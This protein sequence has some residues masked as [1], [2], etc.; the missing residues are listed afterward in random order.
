MPDYDEFTIIAMTAHAFAEERER[1]LAAGMNGHL[2]KPID[3]EELYRL[4]RRILPGG[5]SA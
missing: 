5:E 1:C 3:V 4:L 2:S